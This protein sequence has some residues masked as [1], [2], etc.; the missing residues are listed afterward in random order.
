MQIAHAEEISLDGYVKS[1][2]QLKQRTK[3]MKDLVYRIRKSQRGKD[4]ARMTL[5]KHGSRKRMKVRKEQKN[6]EVQLVLFKD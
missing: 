4:S 3:E 2:V 1:V 6:K 5:Q